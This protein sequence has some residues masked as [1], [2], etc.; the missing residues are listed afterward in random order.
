MKTSKISG[1]LHKNPISRCFL[2]PI[3]FDCIYSAGLQSFILKVNN[4][5]ED[6]EGAE[7]GKS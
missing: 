7:C 3:C 1:R 5:I 2:P 4:I 6:I